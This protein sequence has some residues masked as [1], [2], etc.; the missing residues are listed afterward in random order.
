M[1]N[2]KMKTG[3]TSHLMMIQ[4]MK[5]RKHVMAMGEMI[6]IKLKHWMNQRN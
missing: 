6:M 4:T 2:V 3:V 5:K 1:K